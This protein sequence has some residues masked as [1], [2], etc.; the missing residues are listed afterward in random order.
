MGRAYLG[1]GEILRIQAAEYIVRL[2]SDM[3]QYSDWVEY[4]QRHPEEGAVLFGA[5]KLA[6][7]MGL[8]DGR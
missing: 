8:I 5:M 2:Y 7:E 3:R 4:K 1:Y 6:S